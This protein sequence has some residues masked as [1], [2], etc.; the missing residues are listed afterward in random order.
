MASATRPVLVHRYANRCQTVAQPP[1]LADFLKGTVYLYQQSQRGATFTLLV[2]FSHHPMG[3]FI[4]APERTPDQQAMIDR[5][6]AP[7]T[8]ECF[9][10][11]RP[12][13][14]QMVESLQEIETAQ[15]PCTYVT[16]HEPYYRY[17]DDPPVISRLNPAEQAYMKSV[18]NFCPDLLRAADQLQAKLMGDKEYAVLHLRMGDHQSAHDHPHH[19]QLGH[20]MQSLETE[21]IPRWGKQILILSDSYYT[22][23]FMRAKYGLPCTDFVPV[24]MGETARFLS[25]GEEAPLADIGHTLTEFILLSRSQTIYAHCAYGGPGGF[26]KVTAD[27]YGIPHVFLHCTS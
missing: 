10:E 1:G 24:H 18:L 5:V 21:I 12:I 15:P 27:I 11:H 14:R 9:I 20:V 6:P 17:D 26:S 13:I 25:R 23:M 2:D 16:C 22:K 4:R 19:E 7:P 8:I 3:K